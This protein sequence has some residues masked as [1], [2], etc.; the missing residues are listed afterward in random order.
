[1]RPVA[2][3]QVL[4]EDDVPLN[5][6]LAY[7]LTCGLIG[8]VFPWY[9]GTWSTGFAALMVVAATLAPL[10]FGALLWGASDLF[11]SKTSTWTQSVALA[12]ALLAV[13]PIASFVQML[14]T[15]AALGVFGGVVLPLLYFVVLTAMGFVITLEA[16]PLAG[17]GFGTLGVLAVFAFGVLAWKRAH[18][19][20]TPRAVAEVVVAPPP[21]PEPVVMEK[22][23]QSVE[24][25]SQTWTVKLQSVP[26]GAEVVEVLNG[27][28]RGPTPLTLEFPTSIEKVQVRLKLGNSEKLQT[29]ERH[30]EAFV[31]VAMPQ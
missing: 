13:F 21:A 8:M 19:I 31:V 29:L 24:A 27:R 9:A 28:P 1:V 17:A 3:L 30:G 11:G 4:R 23:K 20:V 22:A 7:G 5:V 14:S 25:P 16:N 26:P 2:I 6:S 15:R 12:A 18:P 10:V